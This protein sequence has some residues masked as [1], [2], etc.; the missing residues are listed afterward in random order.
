LV[1][2]QLNEYYSCSRGSGVWYGTGS[3]LGS[4]YTTNWTGP[5]GGSYSRTW[6]PLGN[7]YNG[8]DTYGGNYS[9]MPLGNGFTYSNGYSS[10]YCMWIGNFLSC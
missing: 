8:W 3:S 5:S 6:M 1:T 2:L 7:S 4:S 10:S 9:I